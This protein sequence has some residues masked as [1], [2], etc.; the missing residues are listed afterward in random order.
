MLIQIINLVKLLLIL[1]ISKRKRFNSFEQK[2]VIAFNRATLILSNS[3]QGR[4]AFC[5]NPTVTTHLLPN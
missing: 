1:I 5:E 2:L 3:F 4:V